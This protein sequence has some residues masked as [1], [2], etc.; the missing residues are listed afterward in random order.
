VAPT[1]ELLRKSLDILGYPS[2]VFMM[3]LQ[4][5]LYHT[6]QSQDVHLL[7]SGFGGNEM[8]SQFANPNYLVDLMK[9]ADIRS[10]ANYFRSQ[11][12][13][14]LRAYARAG[15][16][17]ANFLLKSDRKVFRDKIDAKWK[18]LL[19][20]ET[21]LNNREYRDNFY[22]QSFAPLYQTVKERSIYR[23][24]SGATNE[25]ISC[26]Y[27]IASAYGIKYS[28]PL[29]HPPLIEYFHQVPD[30]WKACHKNGR[31]LFRLAMKDD[32]PANLIQQIK[33]TNT[34]TV[35]FFRVEMEQNFDKVKQ[36]CLALPEQHPVFKYIDQRKIAEAEYDTKYLTGV[37]YRHLQSAATLAMFIDNVQNKNLYDLYKST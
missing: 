29:L 37:K 19:L 35:P 2:N 22:K 36:W 17:Y 21:Y 13:N 26:S 1:L 23:L 18:I 14:S 25:R 12:D 11:G 8:L 24:L 9:K 16:H 30:V 33:P 15:Y 6:A 7:L 3:L 34:S 31:G 20:S 4:E 5:G 32:V 10:M 27:F 28:Y